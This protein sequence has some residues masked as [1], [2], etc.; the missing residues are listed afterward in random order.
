[1][2]EP[3]ECL[4]IPE[5][6]SRYIR[7]GVKVDASYTGDEQDPGRDEFQQEWDAFDPSKE[8]PAPA[9][10]APADPASADPAPADPVPAPDSTK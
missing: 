3:E 1:M 9:D 8:E 7:S 10:P 2:T 6:L 4:T 5:I